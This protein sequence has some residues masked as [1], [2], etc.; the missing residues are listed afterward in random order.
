[1][2]DGLTINMSLSV[3][4]MRGQIEDKENRL[5]FW[6]TIVVWFMTGSNASDGVPY[7]CWEKPNSFAHVQR[8]GMKEKKERNKKE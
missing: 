5:L 7:Y 8:E 6:G 4:S 2:A 3:Q 1:M